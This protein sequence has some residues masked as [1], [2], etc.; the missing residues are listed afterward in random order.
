MT[1]DELRVQAAEIIGGL[2]G[3]PGPWMRETF[4]K[5]PRH[6]FVPDTVWVWRQD[7]Y[8]P[9]RASDEPDTWASLVYDPRHPL[10]TQVD[11]GQ[12]DGGAADA[13]GA[14]PTSSISAL[15]A[16][17]TMLAAADVHPGLKV[18]EIGTGTGYN[19]ALLCERAGEAN[20][21]SVEVDAGLAEEAVRRLAAAGYLPRVVAGDGECG[22]AGCAPY[23][24]V[25]C[26]AS[27]RR[28]PF[29]WVEQTRPGGLIV[30]PW[31]TTLQPHG[32]A[33][34]RVSED[35]GSASGHFG[36]PMSFM[37]LRGQRRP[38]FPL[39]DVYTTKSW[40]ESRD[41]RTN[42]DLS[43]LDDNFHARF[44]LGLRLPGVHADREGDAW[45]FATADS[46]AYV[47]DGGVQQWGPRDLFAEVEG[48]HQ[49]W[50]AAGE[51]ELYEFG[52]TVTSDRQVVW[53][54]DPE[55]GRRW[56]LPV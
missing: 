40:D 43:S 54:A 49:W 21:V 3:F 51:P 41:S 38:E 15:N 14:L 48:A 31:K 5:V 36:R 37:D 4:L 39:K 42:L 47:R 18:L 1:L 50:R 53:H 22:W 12:V 24:R 44:A 30:T 56:E 10:V 2:D 7:A 17:F 23:D 6:V 55:R 45:W 25:L 9:V 8:R 52:L 13:R 26:T 34:L 11:D 46:W 19:A 20:V 35:G 28:V 32:M 16:V 33:C 27:L 29:A